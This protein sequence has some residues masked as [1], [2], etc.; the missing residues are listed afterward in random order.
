MATADATHFEAE[1]SRQAY[2]IVESHMVQVPVVEP[3]E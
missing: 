3:S 1:R 2:E